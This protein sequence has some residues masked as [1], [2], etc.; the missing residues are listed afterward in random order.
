MIYNVPARVLGCWPPW[1][2]VEGSG[3][4]VQGGGCRVQGAGFRVQGAGF[5]VQGA[6][7]RVQGGGCRVEGAAYMQTDYTQR[8]H[9]TAGARRGVFFVYRVVWL[10]Q[11]R[12]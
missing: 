6:G 11:K 5:R 8:T 2:R 10:E 9:P 1:C 12:R 4:R 3:C 7:F